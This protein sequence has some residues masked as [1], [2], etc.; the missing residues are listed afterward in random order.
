MRRRSFPISSA[1]GSVPSIRA[2]CHRVVRDADLRREDPARDCPHLCDQRSAETT[3]TVRADRQAQ[4]TNSAFAL[5]QLPIGERLN[6]TLGGR[7][8]DVAD[9][10]RFETW[11][12]TAAY[13]I[14]ETGTK[15]RPARAPAPRLRHCFS[16][17]P[18]PSARP[19]SAPNRASATTPASTSP[20]QRPGNRFG[21]GLRQPAFRDLIESTPGGG[22]PLQ[23]PYF[24]NVARDLTCGPRGVRTT[25]EIVPSYVRPE[26]GSRLHQPARQEI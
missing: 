10:A 23:Q 17:T 13:S 15:F 21:H 14:F 6:I 3:P 16:S 24:F 20:V 9:V 4:D 26:E 12:A 22:R 11:R 18:P 8:D 5:W 25:I 7:I 19:L 2:R 1:M